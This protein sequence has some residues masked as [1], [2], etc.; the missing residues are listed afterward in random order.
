MKI[1]IV[2]GLAVVVPEVQAIG[3]GVGLLDA[4]L[5]AVDTEDVVLHPIEAL[6]VVGVVLGVGRG[7]EAATD[8]AEGLEASHHPCR[9][10]R[11]RPDRS[12]VAAHHR[13]DGTGTDEYRFSQQIFT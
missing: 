6:V 11:V 2:A 5:E 8:T 12:V 7:V 4:G 3:D 1:E 10:S 9:R 13:Q